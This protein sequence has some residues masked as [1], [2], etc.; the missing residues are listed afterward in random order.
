LSEKLEKL[1]TDEFSAVFRR[2]AMHKW[3]QEVRN[4]RRCLALPFWSYVDAGGSVWGC[5]V[6]MNDDRFLYGNV[7]EQGFREIWQGKDRRRSLEWVQKEHSPLRCRTN[8]RMDEINGYLWQLKH[9][10]VHVNFI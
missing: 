7:Y 1:G 5:G 2:H 3:D 10:P 4:Y 6:Y 9:P 8:C